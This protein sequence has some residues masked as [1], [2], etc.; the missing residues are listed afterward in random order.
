MLR[1]FKYVSF[2]LSVGSWEH[3]QVG[4][5]YVQL[6]EVSANLQEQLYLLRT[7]EGSDASGWG[8]R[9]RT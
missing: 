3:R 7:C 6:L 2:A 5:E 9:H 1:S 8:K 4:D